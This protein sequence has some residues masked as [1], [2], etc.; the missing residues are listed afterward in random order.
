MCWGNKKI[1]F[2][3]R[4]KENKG[5]KIKNRTGIGKYDCKI[6]LSTKF[7]DFLSSDKINSLENFIFNEEGFNLV[8]EDIFS[9]PKKWKNIKF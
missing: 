3:R 8:K 7:E 1:I 2:N 5:F 4:V 6:N 9:N